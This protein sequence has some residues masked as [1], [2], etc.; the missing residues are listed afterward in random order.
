MLYDA[1]NPILRVVA[2]EHMHWDGGVFH[3][4]P[5]MYSVLA[6]RISGTAMVRAGGNEYHVN[7][8]DIL[9]LPQNMAYT[10]TY[11]DTDVLVIHFVTVRDS[12]ELEVYSYQNG[13]KIYKLFMQA[14]TLW[15]NKEPGFAVYALAQLYMILGTILEINTKTNQPQHFLNAVSFI[16]SN[17]KNSA[18]SM[19]MICGEAGI[20]ATVFRQLF[21]KN[22]QKTPTAYITDLRLEHARNLISSGEPVEQAAYAS[23]F[24]DPKYFARVVKKYFG[25]TPR[26][27]KTYGK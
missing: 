9:Y 10:A 11:T 7:T 12:D 17:Y 1:D 25:C 21:K 16:N 4:E 14:L 27:L 15:E 22:Y 20:S 18:L 2:V 26:N 3:V 5:R 6:F 8:N 24:N 19:D 23:G 13:E